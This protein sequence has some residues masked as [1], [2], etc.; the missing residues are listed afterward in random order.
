MKGVVAEGREW[1]PTDCYDSSADI[2]GVRHP[3]IPHPLKT[4]PSETVD[5]LQ[6]N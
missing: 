2:C 4:R 6:C 5:T 1:A 3:G